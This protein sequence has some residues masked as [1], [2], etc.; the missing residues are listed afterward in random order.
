MPD[1]TFHGTGFHFESGYQSKGLAHI[2]ESVVQHQTSFLPPEDMGWQG[3]LQIPTPTQQE[4]AAAAAL[5]SE[6]FDGSGVS[7][8]HLAAA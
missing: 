2:L 6:A 4:T 8:T 1:S 7:R 5:L 3:L